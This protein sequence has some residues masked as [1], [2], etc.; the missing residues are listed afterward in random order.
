MEAIHHKYLV[1]SPMDRDRGLII[2]SVGTQV[3][4]PG[5]S[6]PPGQHPVRYHFTPEQGRILDEFQ[7][8]YITKGSG[9]FRDSHKQERTIKEGDMFL[10]FPGEWHS[11]N[12]DP[13]TGWT[14]MWI[15]FT[16]PFIDQWF[17]NGFVSVQHQVFHVGIKEELKNL[18]FQ[19]MSV[20]DAQES[21]YQQMLC[22][23]VCNLLSSCIYYDR[24]AAY[25]EEKVQDI[26]T[27]VRS[28]INASINEATPES[29]AV[30]A[31]VGYSKLRKLFKQYTGLTLGQ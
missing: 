4:K 19:A 15:G 12:P 14:E 8:L 2:S 23:I 1:T 27:K 28:Y 21:G 20:A 30:Y 26:I 31:G 9:F 25:R 29:A 5:E 6:Y 18:Y 24:N 10:L 11:Y 16:G 3:I 22:G 17:N 7:L 13:G